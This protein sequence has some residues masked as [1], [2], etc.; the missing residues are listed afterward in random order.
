MTVEESVQIEASLER[1]WDTFT[2]LTCWKDWNTVLEDVL[3]EGRSVMETGGRFRC[4]IRPFV[5]GIEFESRIEEVIP[6]SRVVWQGE[7]FG[8]SARHAFEFTTTEANRVR[9]TSRETFEGPTTL[10]AGLLFPWRRI[11]ELTVA[12]LE[13]LK[14]ESQTLGPL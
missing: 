11:R 12:M 14:L 4:R 13:D 5:L 10:V 2:N 9:V 8:I 3:P 7:R 6:Y 1:V